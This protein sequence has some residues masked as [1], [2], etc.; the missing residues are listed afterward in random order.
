MFKLLWRLNSFSFQSAYPIKGSTWNTVLLHNDE[1]RTQWFLSGSYK[2]MDIYILIFLGFLKGTFSDRETFC[3]W[4]PVESDKKHFTGQM[5]CNS[6]VSDIVSLF[7][8]V[9]GFFSK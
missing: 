4:V 8:I 9:K 7:C 1:L 3:H 2:D 5:I 6:E